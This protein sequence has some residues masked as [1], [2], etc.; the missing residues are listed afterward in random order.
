MTCPEI[1]T[2]RLLEIL[3]EIAAAERG[4]LVL[5]LD[6]AEDHRDRLLVLHEG[7]RILKCCLAG[8][9]QAR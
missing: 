7:E 4:R 9:A 8:L 3:G 5:D 2:T 6:A 1:E